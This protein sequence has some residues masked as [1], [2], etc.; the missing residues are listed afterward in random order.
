MAKRSAA[1]TAL[2][3]TVIVVIAGCTET[4]V[5]SQASVAVSIDGKDQGRG[6]TLR[7]NQVQ[8]SWLLDIVDTNGSANGIVDVSGDKVAVETVQIKGFGGFTGG[9]WQGGQYTADASLMNQ[10]FTI[11]GTAYGVKEG[12]P[13]PGTATFKIVARC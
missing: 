3:L 9:Y 12:D 10:T 11:S 2:A 4:E 13:K 7:C 1:V 8:S 5:R 6:L